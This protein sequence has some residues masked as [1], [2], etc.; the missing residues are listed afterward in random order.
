MRSKISLDTAEE[1]GLRGPKPNFPP[2]E[3][4]TRADNYRGFLENIWD[5]FWPKLSGAQTEQDVIS[6]FREVY[7]GFSDIVPARALMV[8]QVKNERSF[9]KRRT[10]RI[11]FMA[12]SLAGLGVVTTRRSRDICAHERAQAKK[13][14]RILR[15]EYYIECSC[16]YTG[17]SR[18]KACLWCGTAIP[19]LMAPATMLDML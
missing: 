16:G 2:G 9:P 19:D 12:D 11:N 4:S 1:K 6:G 8:L 14:H 15:C 3:V 18:D 17:P 5:R 13:A 7:S 10:S